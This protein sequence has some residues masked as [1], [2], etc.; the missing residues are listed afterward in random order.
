[1]K[2]EESDVEEVRMIQELKDAMID[3]AF[4]A[5]GD[6]PKTIPWDVFCDVVKK[7]M[8]QK[9]HIFRDFCKSGPIFKLAIFAFL[10][11]IYTSEIIPESFYHT[12]L[13]TSIV[14]CIDAMNLLDCST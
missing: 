7:V 2:K 9:K 8:I 12:K 3:D 14:W 6:Y 5:R 10:N 4:K 13:T 1:M 11:R